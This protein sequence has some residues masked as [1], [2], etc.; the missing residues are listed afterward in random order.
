[1]KMTMKKPMMNEPAPVLHTVR[2][3]ITPLS[4]DD[5]QVL[6]DRESDPDMKQAYA[7]MLAGCRNCPADRLFYTVWVMR[8]TDGGNDVG[9]LCFKGI[10][11]DGAVEIGYGIYEGY[12]GRGYMTEAVTA[13]TLWALALPSVT[14]VE[15]ETDPDNAASQRVL[16]K[17]GFVPNGLTGE[18]GPRFVYVGARV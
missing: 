6:I 18:E 5:V 15:A 9:N 11:K 8:L 1:M 17:A 2:L 3:T 13:M 4:D 10:A 7:E 12:E 16:E 14:R